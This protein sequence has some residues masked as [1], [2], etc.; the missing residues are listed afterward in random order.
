M[1]LYSQ[2]NSRNMVKLRNETQSEKEPVD[3]VK[4][5]KAEHSSVASLC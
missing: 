4:S 3:S 1:H 5:F 2:L